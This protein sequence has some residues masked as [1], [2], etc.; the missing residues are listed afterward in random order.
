[1]EDEDGEMWIE[2]ES[3]IVCYSYM[4]M[5]KIMPDS[6]YDTDIPGIHVF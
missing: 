6:S 4:Y 1:M 3:L 2:R 5:Y